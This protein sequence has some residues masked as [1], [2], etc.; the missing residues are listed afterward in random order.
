MA[1]GCKR[2]AASLLRCRFQN[3]NPPTRSFFLLLLLLPHCF[4]VSFNRLRCCGLPTFNS[5]N[6]W[7]SCQ[8]YFLFGPLYSYLFQAHCFSSR[9][10]LRLISSLS[11]RCV[12][13]CFVLTERPLMLPPPIR[14]PLPSIALRTDT[15]WT[16][17]SERLLVRHTQI[18]AIAHTLAKGERESE[19]DV[20]KKTRPNGGTRATISMQPQQHN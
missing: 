14:L 16:P 1:F 2:G 9:Y 6:R 20:Q 4:F 3:R 12:C 11:L 17:I 8:F 5:I 10:C 18:G 13:V 19:S 15:T 7:H